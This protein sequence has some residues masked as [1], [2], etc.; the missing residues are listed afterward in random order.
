MKVSVHV[1]SDMS[2]RLPD[3]RDSADSRDTSQ[4]PKNIKSGK[5][6]GHVTQRFTEKRAINSYM[7]Y[8]Y[9][10]SSFFTLFLYIFQSYSRHTSLESRHFTLDSRPSTFSYTHFMLLFCRRSHGLV[11]ECVPHVQHAYFSTLDQS[12]SYFVALSLLFPS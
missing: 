12:N 10:Y 11:N 6:F 5:S 1:S 8:V 4:N 7:L 3:S 9:F 2:L